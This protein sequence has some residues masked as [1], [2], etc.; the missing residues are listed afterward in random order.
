MALVVCMSVVAAP[1]FLPAKVLPK[2]LYVTLQ[3]R[4][5]ATYPADL[6]C[7]IT[8]CQAHSTSSLLMMERRSRARCG[9]LALRRLLP[10]T[11]GSRRFLSFAPTRLLPLPYRP[12]GAV[13]RKLWAILLA[14]ARS[15][16]R[17]PFLGRV[18]SG[19]LLTVQLWAH[20][21]GISGICVVVRKS[22][23]D[24]DGAL[25]RRGLAQV[26]IALFFAA[27]MAPDLDSRSSG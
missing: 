4:A 3:T 18:L 11:N 23:K 26:L 15:L 16:R 17:G 9:S 5:T 20:T 1:P 2:E 19:R 10:K 21:R 24:V 12:G 14:F 13:V 25:G 22:C 6:T 7:L 8:A 27:L